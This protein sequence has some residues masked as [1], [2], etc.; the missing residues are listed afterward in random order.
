M[1]DLGRIVEGARASGRRT[2]LE[3]EVMAL[4]PALGLSAP[5]HVLLP[6]QPDLEAIANACATLRSDE[7][8][9]KVVAP[10][11][12]H[13]T[14]RGGVAFLAREPE[15][16]VMALEQMRARVNEEVAGFLLAERIRYDATLGGELLLSLRYTD[17]FGPVVTL[18]AGGR[19]AEPLGK[20]LLPERGVAVVSP[21]LDL[22][23]RGAALDDKLVSDLLTRS[24]RGRPA[25][26]SRHALDELLG[27]WLAR[28]DAW[29]PDP[30]VELELNPVVLTAQGP[31]AL[32]GFARLIESEIAP[33]APRPIAKLGRMLEPR[34]IAVV[35]VSRGDNPGHLILRRL[36]AAGFPRERLWVVKPGAE[37]VEGCRAV[38]RVEELG[39]RVDLLVVAVPAGAAP[40]II[41]ATIAGDRAESIIVVPGAM[42]ERAVGRDRRARIVT[43]LQRTR[44][45]PGGGPVING[46]NCLGIRSRPG[47]VDT[48]FIPEAKL[49]PREGR[50]EAP[51]A[52][53]SQSG[54]I[55]LSRASKLAPRSPRYLISVGN[56][57]DLTLG[58]HLTH[59]VGDPG[60]AVVACYVEGF[61]PSDGRRWLEAA[62]ALST[63][64]CLVLIHRAGSTTAGAAATRSHTA[65]L[66]G[67]A[68]VTQQLARAAGA[69][70]TSSLDE[71]DDLLLLGS[72][73]HDR[74]VGPGIAALSNAGY[75]CVAFADHAE[76]TRWADLS[77]TTAET[78]ARLVAERELGELVELRNPLDVTPMMDDD[79]LVASAETLLSD[80][81]VEVGLFGLVPM[82]PALSTTEPELS[83][84][85]LVPGLAR[86][87]RQRH[88]AW[89]A[90]VDAGRE[91][92]AFANA[93]AGVGIP[94]FR[95]AD[96]AARAASRYV[97]WRSQHER[98]TT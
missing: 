81:A 39:E 59:L 64:G 1:N 70:V 50:L 60:L 37:N 9:L 82:T 54:A 5:A 87:W 80:P 15:T 11:I 30:L 63:R 34:S 73:W 12:V 79:G 84:G 4:V 2:L 40:P 96:R 98:L 6:P 91:Y 51:V 22:R 19:L 92:D 93:L 61:A 13:K 48:M 21:S 88:E 56:Q 42:G 26:L 18:A 74:T 32:D 76:G 35:G 43:A 69:L 28:A 66:A 71:L 86:L 23:G 68:V 67:D 46:G 24:I 47:R 89:L 27:T 78:L 8:V 10:T 31:M 41:E 57:I 53:V 52:I 95:T 44:T 83:E 7:V 33:P 72:A 55:T 58:D 75:E 29:C 14:E 97:A 20:A 17:D 3:P 49:P 45:K 38:E 62:Q 94:I 25:R 36:L 90:V 85:T 77:P 16:V 65:A